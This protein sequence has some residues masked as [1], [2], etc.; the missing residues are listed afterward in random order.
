MT[1]ASRP[2]NTNSPAS[3]WVRVNV[4]GECWEWTGSIDHGTGYGRLT[5]QGRQVTAHRLAYELAV[6]PIA[7]GLAVCHACDN[8][9]CCRPNHLWLGTPAENLQD[10]VD[11]GRIRAGER[12]G[13]ARLT[14]AAVADIRRGLAAGE[15]GADLARQHRVHPNTV[16]RIGK[17]RT[18]RAA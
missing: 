11:K 16:Y 5:Y 1:T 9:R 10:A 14:A 18:W 3:F 12:H 8:R 13:M 6:G 17:G 7:P 2:P 15:R 4:I